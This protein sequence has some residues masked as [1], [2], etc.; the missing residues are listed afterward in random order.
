MQSAPDHPKESARLKTLLDYEVLD[1]ADEKAFDELTELASTICGTPISLI[2]L[3]DDHRQW[4]KSRVGLD[5]METPKNVAFCSHAI[6]QDKVFEVPNAQEDPRF[7]DN[8]LVTG[9]PDIRF[10]A[11]APLVAPD[12]SAIGTLC[13]IDREPR[14]LSTDQQ[15]ALYVLSKQVIGQ[16]ELRLHNRQLE[17]LNREQETMMASIS[18]DLRS[19]FSAI[20]GLTKRLTGRAEHLSPEGVAKVAHGILNSSMAVYQLLDEMLQWS[21]RRFNKSIQAQPVSL[22]AL[23]LASSSLLNETLRLKQIEYTCDIDDQIQVLADP[24][25]TKSVIRNLLSNAIKFTPENGRINLS[26]QCHLQQVELSVHNSGN[27]ISAELRAK[28]FAHSVDS[29]TGTAGEKGLGL[30]LRLCQEFMEMQG[31][32]IRLDEAQ[33]DGT[34]FIISLPTCEQSV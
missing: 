21:S 26:A 8:P 9:A 15:R 23:T 10:Y 4:F 17:R 12:G 3:V 29:G 19:P 27:P 16:L 33:S 24:T 1:S 11:G 7:S 32:S 30:G 20:L 18:H 14:K 25:L 6:L 2:S 5:A 28:L 34:A 31:G 22:A 13:V